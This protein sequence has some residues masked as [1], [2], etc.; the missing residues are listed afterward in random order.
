VSIIIST[1]NKT[2]QVVKTCECHLIV[3]ESNAFG[4]RNEKAHFGCERQVGNYQYSHK[5]TNS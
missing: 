3:L 2:V 5:A 4:D 1:I